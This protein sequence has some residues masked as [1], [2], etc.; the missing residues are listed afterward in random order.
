MKIV[1]WDCPFYEYDESWD[2]VEEIRFYMCRHP[3]GNGQCPLPKYC[4]E[5]GDCP[6][7]DD[8]TVTVPDVAP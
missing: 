5:V 3:K 8:T 1:C 7:L 2:G 4:S 6:L